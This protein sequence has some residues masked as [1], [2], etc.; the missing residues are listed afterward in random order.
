MQFKWMMQNTLD[1]SDLELP[2]GIRYL[3]PPLLSE[4]SGGSILDKNGH[5]I[6]RHSCIMMAF[7]IPDSKVHGANMGPIWGR[8]DPGGSRVSPMNF[9]IWDVMRTIH[10]Q[11]LRSHLQMKKKV[12]LWFGTAGQFS[13]KINLDCTFVSIKNKGQDCGCQW[14]GALLKSTLVQILAWCHHSH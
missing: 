13:S 5:L 14:P 11:S 4:A 10:R 12:L 3:T 6:R 7:T 8:K 9:A 1:K 2:K